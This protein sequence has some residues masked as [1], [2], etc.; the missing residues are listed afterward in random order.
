[1]LMRTRAVSDQYTNDS[2]PALENDS[3]LHQEND[4]PTSPP[5]PTTSKDSSHTQCRQ[6]TPHTEKHTT[7]IK[8]KVV[9]G[10]LAFDPS[11]PA[12]ARRG[13]VG[14]LVKM[15]TGVRTKGLCR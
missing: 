6:L 1:M 4:T 11:G 2:Q 7:P 3:D 15:R 5:T 10:V 9:K 8:C 13:G 14:V 12:A